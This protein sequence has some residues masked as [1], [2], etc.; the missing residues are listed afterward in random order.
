MQPEDP[1]LLGDPSSSRG[2]RERGGGS[3]EHV[4]AKKGKKPPPA[5]GVAVEDYFDNIGF[6]AKEPAAE[7]LSAKKKKTKT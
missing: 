2:K 7:E 3:G 1:P 5:E 6:D 4:K